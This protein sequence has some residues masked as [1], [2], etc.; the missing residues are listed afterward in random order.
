MTTDTAARLITI[1]S[2]IEKLQAELREL[3]YQ[4][5]AASGSAMEELIAERIQSAEDQLK[6]LRA[7]RTALV[8]AT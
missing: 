7:A 5:T 3:G 2:R 1:D 4:A 8:P 6:E